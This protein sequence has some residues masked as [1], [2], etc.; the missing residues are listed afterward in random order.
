M[1]HGKRTRRVGKADRTDQTPERTRQ[2][3]R[4]STA[5]TM[6]QSQCIDTSRMLVA[7]TDNSQAAA[8][9][10]LSPLRMF[11]RAVLAACPAGH[12]QSQ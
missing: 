11:G 6:A 9:G 12:S 8:F 5:T 1:P 7:V 4:F 10:D 3:Q 2:N